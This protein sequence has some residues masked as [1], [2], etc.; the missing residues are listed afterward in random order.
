MKRFLY[1]AAL[2]FLMSGLANLARADEKDAKAIVDKGIMALGG[3]EKLTKAGA[4]SWK[5]KGT[6]TFN[7][8]DNEFSSQS[9]LEGL[10]HYRS[11]FDGKFGDMEVKGITVLNGDKAWQR[12]NENDREV[13]ADGIIDEKHRI[14]IQ[15]IPTTLVQLKGKGFKIDSAAEE[16]VGDKPAAVIKVTG[17]EG[18]DFTLYFDKESGLPVKL[19]AKVAGFGGGEDFTQET[20]FSDYK[21]FDG[22]KKATKISSKRDGEK[23]VDIVV[24]DFKVLDKVPAETFSQPK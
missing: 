23:F 11:E 15:A 19:V 20:I 13:D 18:K 6:I 14:N 7:G 21:D 4:Y 24:S 1:V 10:D 22:I 17:P 3:E 8:S 9:T 2:T 5:S 12:F 16:K